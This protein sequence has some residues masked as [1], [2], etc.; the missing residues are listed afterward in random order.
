MQK[1]LHYVVYDSVLL[2]N[3][4]WQEDKVKANKTNKT[5]KLKTTNLQKLSFRKKIVSCVETES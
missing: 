4:V 5:K 1:L 2:H 3:N